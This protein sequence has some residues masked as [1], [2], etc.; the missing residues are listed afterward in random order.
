MAKK[1]IRRS[2]VNDIQRKTRKK[3]MKLIVELEILDPE[4][5]KQLKDQYYNFDGVELW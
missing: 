5:A 1:M 4:I 3:L 2:V